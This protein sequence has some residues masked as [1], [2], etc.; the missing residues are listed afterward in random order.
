M[1]ITHHHTV[2]RAP[3]DEPAGD[4]GAFPTNA[5]ILEALNIQ[6]VGKTDD[7]P[8]EPAAESPE[9]AAEPSAEPATEPAPEPAPDEL[10]ALKAKIAELEAKLSAPPA[11]KPDAEPAPVAVPG[12]NP[13]Y[14]NE[15]DID[16]RQD[17]LVDMLNQVVLHLDGYEGMQDG[18]PVRLTAEQVR[19]RFAEL[20]KEL[21]I[22]L[23]REREALRK[24]Q[25][26]ASEARRSYPSHFDDRHPDAAAVR[27]IFAEYP[28]IAGNHKLAAEL[29][30]ARKAPA[31]APAAAPAKA[32]PK[33][34]TPPAV[35][36]ARGGAFAPAS[37]A[38]AKASLTAADFRNL[39]AN[40][41]A[42]SAF[43]RTSW[44]LQ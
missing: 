12:V 20:N 23:P 24:V 34:A 13:T 19:A 22:T 9:P 27:T 11:A 44:G 30:K 35:P 18:K 39:G 3:A 10:G 28:Q 21:Q 33:A 7:E 40:A 1:N 4:A 6:V 26:A 2:R 36:T 31:V 17:A 38:P 16:A 32:A 29:L 41:D 8:A 43:I 25:A 5:D 37:K 15:A 42:A 14:K